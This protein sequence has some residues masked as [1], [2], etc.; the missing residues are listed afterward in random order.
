MAS[1]IHAIVSGCVKLSSQLNDFAHNL[2]GRIGTTS[3]KNGLID[4]ESSMEAN[5][6]LKYSKRS[7]LSQNHDV[8]YSYTHLSSGIA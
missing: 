7:K 6:V 8:M 5:L 1:A 4:D 2:R 3:Q